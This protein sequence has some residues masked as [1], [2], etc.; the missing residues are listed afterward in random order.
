MYGKRDTVRH[1]FGIIFSG[2]DLNSFNTAVHSVGDGK[3]I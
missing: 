3:D 1:I 2:V